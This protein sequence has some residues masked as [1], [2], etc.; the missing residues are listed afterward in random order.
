MKLFLNQT[1]KWTFD[2]EPEDEKPIV[3]ELEKE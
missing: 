2:D 3:V 1:Y